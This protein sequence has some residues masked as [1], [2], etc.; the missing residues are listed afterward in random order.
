MELSFSS[1][2]NNT[3]NDDI[4]NDSN[5]VSVNQLNYIREMIESMNKFNQIEVLRLLSKHNKDVIFNENK[6]GVHI[7]LSELKKEII[8]ELNVFIDYVTTQEDTLH[9]FEKQKETFKNIYFT[10]DNKDNSIK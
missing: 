9:Q 3:N 5:D 1:I 7:N 2:I 10:K 4:V 6:Y 8:D